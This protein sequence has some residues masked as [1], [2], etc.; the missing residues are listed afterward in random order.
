MKNTA[1]RRLSALC[2]CLCALLSL[3][4]CEHKHKWNDWTPVDGTNHTRTCQSCEEAEV[5]AH[6]FDDGAITK[7]ATDVDPGTKTYTCTDCGYTRTEEIPSLIQIIPEEFDEWDI[8]TTL[9]KRFLSDD[10]DNVNKYATGNSEISYPAVR[11][12]NWEVTGVEKEQIDHYEFFISEKEDLSDAV[13]QTTRYNDFSVAKGGQNLK[14]RTVYYWQAAVVL[15]DG[16]SVKSK[17]CSFE[18]LDG[19]RNLYVDG[20]ANVRDIGGKDC[21]GGILR[22]GL[23]YRCGRLH[24]SYSDYTTV[25]I[26][27]KG[28]ETMLSWGIKTEIDLRGKI[29]GDYKENGSR[30]DGSFV[31]DKSVLGDTVT[32]YNF[33]ATYSN[34][35][36]N[37]SE[38]KKMVKDTFEVLARPESY[39]LCFHCSIG[40]D[41]TGI[42]A[43]LIE[44]VCG[45]NKEEIYYDYLFSNFGNIGSKRDHERWDG[46][47]STIECNAGANFMEK[48]NATL[49]KCGVTQAQID[50][51]RD[52]LI[53][54]E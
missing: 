15:T 12:F 33:G 47:M 42:I 20:V 17:I 1:L 48:C 13:A 35:M 19:P 11:T 44:G 10:P 39:P 8:H 26:T 4:S 30:V 28:I 37:G 29:S 43:I 9:Q 53:E 45:V 40:T 5:A 18:T 16:R 7:E 36:L 32:Y 52:I 46:I 38:G 41:R 23:V 54:A 51:V 27:K 14:V 24:N 2:L 21:D 34:T 49:L 25:K 31:F 50:A 6:H 3:V 22:Q